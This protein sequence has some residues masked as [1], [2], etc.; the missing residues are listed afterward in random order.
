MKKLLI[1]GSTGFIGKNMYDYF[2]DKYL[3]YAPMKIQL[4]ALSE[5]N[6]Y[7]HLSKNYYDVIINAL[8]IREFNQY[9]LEHRLRM[10]TNLERFNNLYGK[11]IYFGS[12]AEYARELPI[13][14][15]VEDEFDRK[16]PEDTYGFCL[17]Q[18][19]KSAM[20]SKNIYNFRL[21]GIFG[22]YEIWQ[23]R[24]ISNAICKALYGYPIT[25]RQNTVFDYLFIDDL[26]KIVEWAIEATP[27]YHDY[28]AVSGKKYD[29][30][31]LADIIN[32]IT[33]NSAPVLIA[34]EGYDKEY[35][36][37]CGRLMNEIYNYKSE[38]IEDSIRKMIAWYQQNLDLIDRQKLLYQ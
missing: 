23:K 13:N 15:I 32:T 34:S 35:T 11:M 24:F 28:N 2:K 10:Y 6:I 19:S 20:I 33:K 14:S 29:L 8:D 3:V 21:F 17:H 31:E 26:C 4:D 37:S 1:L 25:I 36:A 16:I 5:I 38:P 27:N 18:I 7:E 9:Y 12:G 30:K 22:K